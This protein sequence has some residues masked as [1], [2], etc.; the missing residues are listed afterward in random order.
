M[1]NSEGGRQAPH[2]NTHTHRPAKRPAHMLETVSLAHFSDS[3]QIVVVF[4]KKACVITGI[5]GIPLYA[6]AENYIL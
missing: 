4:W 6:P 2:T 3:T 1:E 5:L